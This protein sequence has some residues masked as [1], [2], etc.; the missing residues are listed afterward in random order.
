M[1]SNQKPDVSGALASPTLP[2]S[3]PYYKYINSPAEMGMSG[4]GSLS[5]LGKDID[6]LIAY[7]ELL[8]QGSGKASKTGKPL[9]NKFFTNTGG[10]CTDPSGNKQTRSMYFDFVPD[11]TI[12]FISSGMGGAKFTAFEGLIPGALG[13]LEVLN[14]F[15][16]LNAFTEGSDPSCSNITLHVI[17]NSNNMSMENNFVANADIQNIDPCNFNNGTNYITNIKCNQGFSNMNMYMDIEEEYN[18]SSFTSLPD[19]I[20]SKGYLIGLSVFGLFILYKLM[21]KE[22]SRR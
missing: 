18:T 13:D 12:P 15:A 2:P 9:G 5:V 17:D 11:G 6:G 20:I 16:I 1:S 22:N 4:K 3:Y 21:L 14:P 8:V 19:D 7:V 10:T